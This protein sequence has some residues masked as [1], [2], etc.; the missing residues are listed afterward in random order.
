MTLTDKTTPAAEITADVGHLDYGK[1]DIR[2]VRVYRDGERHN[3]R[4]VR[5]DVLV[6]GRL[7][8]GYVDGDNTD[9][10]A[11]D[12]IRH[13]VYVVA[14]RSFTSSIE[15]FGKELV[16]HYVEEGPLVQRATVKITENQWSR[17]PAGENGHDHAFVRDAGVRSAT[18]MGDGTDFVVKAGISDL[19]LLKTTASGW[20]NFLRDELTILPETNDRILNTSVDAEWV[21]AQSEGIDFDAVWGAARDQLLESFADHYSPGLQNDVYVIGRAILAR[22]PDID[23]IRFTLPNLH[24]I[25]YDLTRFGGTNNKRVFHADP[26][27]YGVFH[28]EIIRGA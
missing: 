14:D 2:L 22:V 15:E 24:N 27:P 10:L 19:T 28:G 26:E 6:E 9:W 12:N 25:E 13:G 4:D 3:F 23:R 8:Q 11:T 21:Y 17:I 18:V 7:R 1:S 5:V 20:E 16:R